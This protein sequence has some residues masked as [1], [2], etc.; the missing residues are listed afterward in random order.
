M[1]N[2]NIEQYNKERLKRV[3]DI[4]GNVLTTEGYS[5]AKVSANRSLDASFTP[6]NLVT[7]G[8]I[9]ED[10]QYRISIEIM[11]SATSP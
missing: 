6:I 9:K 2:K 10:I 3:I 1:F 8:F 5:N 4:I 7:L 11:G